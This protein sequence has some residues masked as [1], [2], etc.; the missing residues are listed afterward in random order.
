MN[1]RKAGA[2]PVQ[3]AGDYRTRIAYTYNIKIYNLKVE[4]D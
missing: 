2:T 3:Q 1:N 4:E